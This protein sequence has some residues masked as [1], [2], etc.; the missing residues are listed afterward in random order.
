M[1]FLKH[2][3]YQHLLSFLI[4]SCMLN[5]YA[6][7]AEIEVQVN[8]IAGT[9]VENAV[10]YLEPKIKAAPPLKIQASIVQKNKTFIPLVTIIQTGSSIIFPNK[11]SVRH[12]VYSFSPAK[13]FELKLY[14]GVPSIPVVFDKTGTVILGCNIHDQMLA[15]VYIVDTPYFAKTDANGKVKISGV[16]DGDYLLK[17]WHYALRKENVTV[18]KL[19]STKD[20][21]TI[22]MVIDTKASI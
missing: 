9:S 16:P 3:T 15:F 10:V 8:D 22:K 21:D 11:D 1:P 19:V 4:L 13:T 6:R 17:V 5:P 18:D 20:T 7:A 12:H 2:A 14:S